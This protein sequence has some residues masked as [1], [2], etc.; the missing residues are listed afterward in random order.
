MNLG[1]ICHAVPSSAEEGMM[2]LR[3]QN[4]YTENLNE[5]AQGKYDS[6]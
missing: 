5:A 4:L 1:Q 6:G 3:G 2:D